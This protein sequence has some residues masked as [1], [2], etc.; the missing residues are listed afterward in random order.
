MSETPITRAARSGP[1]SSFV[2]GL[3]SDLAALTQADWFDVQVASPASLKLLA[4]VA[5]LVKRVET[6]GP[7]LAHG[8]PSHRAWLAAAL[9]AHL[10]GR[11]LPPP[12]G[13]LDPTTGPAAKPT[14]VNSG[15]SK[16][17]SAGVA[18]PDQAEALT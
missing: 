10:D 7:A 4:A 3:K 6:I 15:A 8:N 12:D 9:A 17:I 14:G 1:M 2:A 11:P 18:R 5:D 16:P 13:D